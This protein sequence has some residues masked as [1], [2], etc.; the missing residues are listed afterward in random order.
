MS[1]WTVIAHY[2]VPSGG[3]ASYTFSSIPQ[4]YTDL[5]L[6]T[7]LRVTQVANTQVVGIRINSNTSNYSER[8]LQGDG[9]AGAS[10]SQSTT[11]FAWMTITNGANTAA[12]TFNNA[13][14]YFPNYTAAVAKSVSG[15]SVA[16]DNSASTARL[17]LNAGLWN[18]T[19][20]ISS[21]TILP[22]ADNLAQYSSATLYG[23]LKGSSGGVTVS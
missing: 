4:T 10:F 9:S 15:D 1:A 18:D 2:E 20:A 21:L 14:I 6:V 5:L 3:V 8:L 16:E 22:T 12:S 17:F 23:I 11:Q 13:S 7:S 19:T